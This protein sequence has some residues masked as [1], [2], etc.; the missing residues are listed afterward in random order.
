MSTVFRAK[1]I[2]LDAVT[3]DDDAERQAFLNAQCGD[4][5][6]LRSLIDRMFEADSSVQTVL[7][8]PPDFEDTG[9]AANAMEIPAVVGNFTIIRELGSGGMGIVYEAM[10]SEPKRQVALK[11]FAGAPGAEALRRF[12][13][14]AN[15]LARLAHPGI[16]SIYEAGSHDDGLGGRPYFAMQLVEGGLPIDQYALRHQLNTRARLELFIKVCRAIAYGHQRGIIHRDI[17]PTNI[18]VGAD[19]EPRVIDFGVAG[20]A[21]DSALSIASLATSPGQL[22][23]TLRYISPEQFKARESGQAVVSGVRG[24]VYSLGVVLYELLAGRSPYPIEDISPYELPRVIREVD[25]TRLSR[26]DHRMRG[27]LETI[28]LKTLAK[29]PERRYASVESLS[30]DIERFLRNEPIEARRDHALYQLRKSMGRYRAAVAVAAFVML[31]ATIAVIA[32]ARLY[33]QAD[34]AREETRVAYS[35]LERT[36]YFTSIALASAALESS[37]VREARTALAQCPPEM[38]GWEWHNLSARIDDSVQTIEPGMHLD[39]VR[40]LNDRSGFFVT[41]VDGTT[42]ELA[43]LNSAGR[44]IKTL[45]KHSR[46]VSSLAISP[47]QRLVAA[48]A[49]DGRIWILDISTGAVLHQFSDFR[50]W[51]VV[52]RFSPDSK[53]LFAASGGNVSKYDVDAGTLIAT[54]PA[55]RDNFMVLD[56]S[57]DGSVFATASSFDGTD[58]IGNDPYVRLWNADSMQLIAELGRHNAGI[59]G[60]CFSADGKHL[61]SGSG[62]GVLKRWDV[63]ARS[64]DS[65]EMF[66]SQILNIAVS[67]D[68]EYV[69]VSL[70]TSI[71]L[72]AIATGIALPSL[73]GHERFINSATFVGSSHDIVTCDNVSIKLSS[74]EYRG[75]LEIIDRT[76]AEI[77]GIAI[78]ADDRFLACSH[79]NGMLS[80]YSQ[81]DH[82]KLWSKQAHTIRSRAVE[83]SP[84]SRFV[85]T[86]GDDGYACIW[87]VDNGTLVQKVGVGSFVRNVR[88]LPEPNQV[89]FGQDAGDVF[90]CSLDP[91]KLLGSV[92]LPTVRAGQMAV[93]TDGLRLAVGNQNGELTVIDIQKAAIEA[94]V[95]GGESYLSAHATRDPDQFVTCDFTGSIKVWDWDSLTVLDTLDGHATTVQSISFSPDGTRMVSTAHGGPPILWDFRSHRPIMRLQG[96]RDQVLFATFNSTG[97]RI[98][99][100]S[101]LRTLVCWHNELTGTEH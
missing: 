85:A 68:N 11:V 24:D 97:D 61:Y 94:V 28:V 59:R 66:P 70:S 3:I 40:I 73:R 12:R 60:V 89:V 36:N 38:R 37:Q 78:S 88:W 44:K 16:A 67:S 46:P 72:R 83:F 33:D 101:G 14:E 93:A 13:R 65:Q 15:I 23:G 64:F 42:G 95:R 32:L 27:D 52:L 21:A 43:M 55:Q 18:L 76:D 86:G 90:F 4:D 84:D 50:N 82:R 58:R 17:K 91:P 79:E 26:I 87:N 99:A 19:G 7:D 25:P 29:D 8:T 69:A 6:Q 9:D 48:G 54:I 5:Q 39:Q 92:D 31:L 47:D 77:S 41:A 71:E 45:I 51:V 75:G 20:V 98:Y 2:F 22:I 1:Q 62:D 81:L 63:E 100:R 56:L 53:T 57:R 10:Q 34:A 74:V 49:H 96:F 80:V 30:D 35:D